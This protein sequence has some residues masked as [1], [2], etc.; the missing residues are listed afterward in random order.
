MSELGYYDFNAYSA[1]SANPII[2]AKLL[3]LRESPLAFSRAEL[4]EFANETSLC[5]PCRSGDL[6]QTLHVPRRPLS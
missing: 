3:C 2:A 4:W 6:R 1:E 5:R